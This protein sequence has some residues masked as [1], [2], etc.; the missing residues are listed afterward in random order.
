MTV[1]MAS[2]CSG[3]ALVLADK[4]IIISDGSKLI[5][6][7]IYSRDLLNGSV[8][9]ASSALDGV[10]SEYLATEILDDLEV[11]RVTAPKLIIRSACQ[12]NARMA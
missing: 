12:K 9:L 8:A 4:N 7:K 11:R 1:A 5:G 3:G 6:H 2:R 10:A